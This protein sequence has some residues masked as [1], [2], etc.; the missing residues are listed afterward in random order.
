M[1]HNTYI[2]LFPA[3]KYQYGALSF[4]RILLVSLLLIVQFL[5]LS[6]EAG[7][8]VR[9]GAYENAPKIF[10]TENDS[11]SGFWPDLIRVIAKE[12][13]WHIKWVP[14]TWTECM[15]RLDC[16]EID[17]MPDVA[18]SPDR[19]EKYT[20]SNDAVLVSWSRLY[21]ARGSGV[22]TILD[23]KHKIIGG[24]AGS[25]NLDGPQGLKHLL[26]RFDIPVIF[27]EL[28]SYN[29]VFQ[30]L[31][32]GTI[33]VGITNK[34]FG[35]LNVDRYNVEP[36]SILLQPIH[37]LFAF[38]QQAITIPGLID[39]L[40][41][42]FKELKAVHDS[43]YYQ[44]MDQWL[45]VKVDQDGIP[46]WVVWANAVF[47]SIIA[48]ILIFIVLLRHQVAAGSAKLIQ[49]N[50]DLRQ[51]NQ[52]R[53]K[54]EEAL[55]ISE[56]RLRLITDNSTDNIAITSF[57]L[58]ATYLYVNASVKHTM[59]YE[60]DD[61]IG[62]S[63]WEFIHPDD[64]KALLPLLKKYIS[65]KINKLLT[66]KEAEISETIEFRFK[67][68]AGNWR[69]MQ[70]AV[71]IAGK[72]LLAVTR[73]ITENYRANISLKESEAHYRQLFNSLPYGG[74]II[75][76]NGVILDCSQATVTML[77]YKMEEIIGR[78]ITDFVDQPTKALYKE[79]MPSLL[80]GK[81]LALE[82]V[83]LHKSG[84]QISVLRA[85]EPIYD[86]AGKITAMLALSVDITERKKAEKDR[87][88]LELQLH[89]SRKLETVGTMVGGIAHDFNNILQS[90]FLYSEL[91]QG[92]L[93]DDQNLQADFQ[94]VID[95]G[96]RAQ[97][98][99]EQILT[100]SRKSNVKLHA[101][102]IHETV[103]DALSFQRA[104]LPANITLNQQVDSDCGQ[105]V[106]DR[107]QVHQ[108]VLNLCNNAK[109]AIGSENGVLNV[110]L[111][112]VGTKDKGSLQLKVSDSGQGMD[113]D[114]MDKIFDPF[115]TTKRVGEGTGLG[116]SVI[117]GIVELM[118]GQITVDSKLGEGTT[119]TISIPVAPEQS[120]REIT[121]QPTIIDD[122][123]LIILLVD[124]EESIRESAEQM[125]CRLGHKVVVKE[126]GATALLKF[127]A[128]PEFYDI[129]VTDLSMPN[130]SGVAL[131]QKIRMLNQSVPILLSSGNLDAEAENTYLEQ[132]VTAF[133]HK[134][135]THKELIEKIMVL[136]K[137]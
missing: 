7:Q 57:D 2:F 98:L 136:V 124:D 53:R 6:L 74:E 110:S 61:L 62:R 92:Q 4:P 73:D 58:K 87:A 79:N 102:T 19:A 81:S 45:G 30:A 108:I 35:R 1:I 96:K 109:Y 90:M 80:Q 91:V 70:S 59:G 5:P 71:T 40:N 23:L 111:Q 60:P 44:L 132:G 78:R 93:G 137:K 89:Q 17:L 25:I 12:E 27:K 28:G 43:E 83:M 119:F 97:K 106:C 101:Q 42:H 82:A 52:Q 135:W 84:R 14:G 11:I 8:V 123:K 50:S 94:H 46:V 10:T 133:I 55:R 13:D 88:A 22:E 38:S 85:A 120:T 72:N 100:F 66:G 20:L 36:T 65:Q 37:L 63:F 48:I 127:Q 21:V 16:N 129:V 49:S 131:A 51:E 24:L 104:S 99:V 77:G 114:T 9:V 18:W 134:P 69:N 130:L 41:E 103:N 95:S 122:R 75:D 115:Y 86:N 31:S 113:S 15:A 105:V 116:L 26:Q 56:E 76:L 47:V 117:H 67:N 32:D 125:L 121:K 39:V 64:K 3:N 126:D 118:Q 107:T 34:D 54:S 29:E 33:D 128:Q 112:Q 68:K